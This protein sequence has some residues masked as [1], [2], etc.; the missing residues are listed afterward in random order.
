MSLLLL[1]NKQLSGPSTVTISETIAI[2]SNVE[3]Q[4]HLLV[5][6]VGLIENGIE[7]QS[8]NMFVTKEFLTRLLARETNKLN[9]KQFYNFTVDR[10]C[11]ACGLRNKTNNKSSLLRPQRRK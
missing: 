1:G 5:W 11:V 3:S 10:N 9:N 7:R 2:F 8:I 6:V 4:S